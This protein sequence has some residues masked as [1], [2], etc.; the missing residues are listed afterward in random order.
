MHLTVVTTDG[1]VQNSYRNE[2]QK[3]LTLDD[4]FVS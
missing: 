1:L 2:I 3:E 4:L